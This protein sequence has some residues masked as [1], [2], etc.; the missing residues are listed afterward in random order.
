MAKLSARLQSGRK[1]LGRLAE[2]KAFE[3]Y[4]RRGIVPATLARLKAAA[5]DEQKFLDLCAALSTKALS[6]GKAE[7]WSGGNE[8]LGCPRKA[9]CNYLLHLRRENRKVWSNSGPH[10]G[11]SR[12]A[13][14]RRPGLHHGSATLR[15]TTAAEAK[16]LCQP[17]LDRHPDFIFKQRSLFRAPVRHILQ[18]FST[19]RMSPPELI[20]TTWYAAV[21]SSPPPWPAGGIGKFLDGATG[22][23]DR[24]G[25]ASQF[26]QELEQA[27]TE[28]LP[29]VASIQGVLDYPYE[30]IF[31]TGINP[32]TKSILLAALG[33]F[34]EAEGVLS[35]WMPGERG[36]LET[37]KGIIRKH[38][39]KGSKSW[40]RKQ[41][42]H[43]RIAEHL[44]HVE[45]LHDLLVVGRPEPIASLLHE[46]EAIGARARHIER[47]W[48]PSPF[49]FEK[50]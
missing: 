48:E 38:Y 31:G 20:R 26:L 40:K 29:H 11:N 28:I 3:S 1:A 10:Q 46:W 37:D 41:D 30:P 33:R 32:V 24:P 47:Y 12:E 21:M 6:E 23:I 34:D 15:M 49:P 25:F 7:I 45:K 42:A 5:A 4:M 27:N 44:A 9:K 16:Y 35:A 43:D 39:R 2:R 8:P 22:A 19:D 13:A 14:G 50:V 17:F 18:G 36:W